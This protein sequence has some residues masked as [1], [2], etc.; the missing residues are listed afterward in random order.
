LGTV[1]QH[2]AHS[3]YVE[4]LHRTG[5]VLRQACQEQRC[6]FDPAADLAAVVRR[7]N[8]GVGVFDLMIIASV[9]DPKLTGQNFFPVLTLLHLAGQGNPGPLNEAIDALQ[10]GADTPPSQYSSGLHI[11]TLCAD[12]TDIPWGSPAAP[13]AGRDDAIARAL[14]GVSPADVWPFEP[15]T[16]VEQGII[17]GCRYWPPSRPNQQA[18]RPRLTMPVLLINGDRDLSTPVEWAQEEVARTVRGRL[19]IIP[20]MGHSI[21]GR[22][23]DGDKAVREFLIG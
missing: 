21:Q 10:G 17:Q 12:L 3:L 15:R 5:W 7:Y 23:A 20:G 16:T 11:A 9:V 13:L 14:A 22:N 18:R 1:P 19:V 4:S 8:N 6:G 2:D